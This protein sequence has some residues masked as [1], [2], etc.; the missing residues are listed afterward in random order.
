MISGGCKMQN[1]IEPLYIQ[2]YRRLIEDIQQG[3]YAKN[4]RLPS[5]K[6]VSDMFY[7]SRITS[8]KAL[9]KLAE[10]NY[11]IRIKGKG[12]YVSPFHAAQ[13]TDRQDK[14]NF[15]GIILPDF[16]DSFG[17]G[18]LAAVERECRNN[19]ILCMMY[20]SEGCQ[21]LEQQCL[22][23]LINHGVSGII[24]MPVHDTYYN[25]T[26]LRLVLDGFPIVVIDRELKGIPSHFV[27][28]NNAAAAKTAMDVLINSGHKKI[29]VYSPSSCKASSLEDR[30]QGVLQSIESHNRPV[31]Q[32]LFFSDIHSTLPSANTA[33]A[34]EKDRQ[35]VAAHLKANPDMTAILAMEYQIALVV[36]NAA[37]SINLKIPQDISI[38]CFDSPE[39]GHSDPAIT[40]YEFAHIRQDEDLM[41]RKTFELLMSLIHGGAQG[42]PSK[43][44]LPFSIMKGMSAS[45]IV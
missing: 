8:R 15:I 4:K 1:S 12:S 13:E 10:D 16:S 30:L 36:K 20:R 35:S 34:L 19:N 27:G 22:E 45:V 25:A 31:I 11:I 26:I 17:R 40:P 9:D 41:G 14:Q 5:E 24:I 33:E 44:L 29:G 21:K 37:L 23:L 38:F 43:V 2:I 7:V 39:I 6:E 3:K 18:I 42:S 32:G 28:T